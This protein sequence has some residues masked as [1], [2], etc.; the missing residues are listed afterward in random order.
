MPRTEPQ[1]FG[2]P[3]QQGPGDER[4]VFGGADV[5]QGQYGGAAQKHAQI[6]GM[7]AVE[8]TAG[9]PGP[10]R[11]EPGVGQ[12]AQ[13]G[14]GPPVVAGLADHAGDRGV[15]LAETRDGR[16]RRRTAHGPVRGPVRGPAGVQIPA[17]GLVNAGQ[18][19]R[20]GQGEQ[21]VSAE[22]NVQQPA[23]QRDVRLQR[24]ARL[25]GQR[26][27]GQRYGIGITGIDDRDRGAVPA[28]GDGLVSGAGRVDSQPRQ[29][30]P[31]EL[32]EDVPDRSRRVAGSLVRAASG[33]RSTGGFGSSGFGSSGREG[34]RIGGPGHVQA[35]NHGP[36]RRLLVATSD[37]PITD[38]A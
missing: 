5:V 2:E 35:G 15:Q 17:G 29:P 37:C 21:L 19:Q 36:A 28:G 23:H 14:P 27:D 11:T 31:G 25:Q 20:H 7:T 12:A 26:A 22:G 8:E 38:R 4:P 10:Q 24:V 33:I 3:D 6:G 9:Q 32:R 1:V 16:D 30:E 13:P 34:A 18:R